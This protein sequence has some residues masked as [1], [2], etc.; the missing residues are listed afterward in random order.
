MQEFSPTVPVKDGT[1]TVRPGNHEVLKQECK[2]VKI[3]MTYENGFYSFKV[4][5]GGMR[6]AIDEIFET[7]FWEE[8]R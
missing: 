3:N 8:G 5:R 1:S 7:N 6:S 4:S 2:D